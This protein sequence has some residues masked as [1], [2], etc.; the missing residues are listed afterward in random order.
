MIFQKN[1]RSILIVAAVQR[2]E[3]QNNGWYKATKIG[4]RGRLVAKN[5]SSATWILYN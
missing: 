1:H 4:L 3:R 5:F 2:L